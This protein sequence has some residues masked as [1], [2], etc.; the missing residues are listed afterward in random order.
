MDK[1]IVFIFPAQFC[2]FFGHFRSGTINFFYRYCSR[3][4]GTKMGNIFAETQQLGVAYKI[5]R[6]FFKADMYLEHIEL[7][8]YLFSYAL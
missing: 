1:K 4:N 6:Q 7:G 8:I 3:G 5:H 2:Q